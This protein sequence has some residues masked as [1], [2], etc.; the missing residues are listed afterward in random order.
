MDRSGWLAMAK[1]AAKEA[2]AA[3]MQVY[4]ST[5]FSVEYKEDQSPLT[6]ADTSAHEIIKRKLHGTGIPILSEEGRWIPYTER[7]NWDDFWMV[8]PLDGTKE[9]IKRTKE[10]TVNIAMI[11]N[12]EPVFG[13]VYAP[14]LKLLYWN[15][16]GGKA[17]KQQGNEDARQIHTQPRESVQYIV[18]SKSHLTQETQ[19]YINRFPGASLQ[20]IGSSLKFMLVAEG[21]ADCYPR[22]GPTMEWDTAAAHAVAKCSGCRVVDFKTNEELR[23]NKENLLNPYFLVSS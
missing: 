1:E 18:A 8:D 6:I 16:F 21:I 7:R 4:G 11:R 23:Y 2:G 10:F 15:D 3:I 19:E 9:F 12:Q 13:V 20:T 14:A 22:F 5:N 17:W